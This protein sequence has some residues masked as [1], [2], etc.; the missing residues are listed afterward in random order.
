MVPPGC[1]ENE[2]N[3]PI[4]TLVTFNTMMN[5]LCNEGMSDDA[6]AL[7]AEMKRLGLRPDKFTYTALMRACSNDVDLEEI[8]YDMKERGVQAAREDAPIFFQI[9]SSKNLRWG[10]PVFSDINMLMLSLQCGSYANV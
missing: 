6:F 9:A 2:Q 8:L 1:K 3:R 5:A 7:F 4:Q 10:L